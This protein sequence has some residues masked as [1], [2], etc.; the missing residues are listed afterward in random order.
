MLTK[1]FF[2][3]IIKKVQKRGDIVP[4]IYDRFKTLRKTKKLSQT[5]FGEQVG[6]SRSV[7]TNIEHKL[8]E[9]KE[10]F[11]KQ[12]CKEYHVNYLWLTEGKGDMLDESEDM[13]LEE[14][15]DEYKLDELDKKIIEVYIK[16]S[17]QERMELKKMLKKIFEND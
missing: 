3:Y 10:L 4:D 13:L 8:V 5:E 16:L 2:I 1:H 6:V 7:I 14:L 12:V 15:A 17:H 11:I 9:P